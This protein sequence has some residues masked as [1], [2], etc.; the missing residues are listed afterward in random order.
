MKAQR[1]HQLK[2]NTLAHSLET[3]P[4]VSRR[5]GTKIL[6]VVMVG[7]IV[8]IRDQVPF[9]INF[10]SV[11]TGCFGSSNAK[12]GKPSRLMTITIRSLAAVWVCAKV[13]RVP[14]K[15]TTTIRFMICRVYANEL[16]YARNAHLNPAKRLAWPVPVLGSAF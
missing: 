11:G 16:V 8:C 14:S 13:A 12:P 5:H 4:D 1:R 9:P 10:R 15:S 2:Q 3:L 7:L 6:V